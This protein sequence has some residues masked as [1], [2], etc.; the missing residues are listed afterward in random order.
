LSQQGTELIQVQPDRFIHNWRKVGDK[1]AYPRYER[2]KS[3]FEKELRHFS[4]FLS[5]NQM[6]DLN[7]NQCEI[8][9]VNHITSGDGWKDH[10]QIGDVLTLFASRYTDEFRPIPE[11]GRLS[12][13]YVIPNSAGEPIGRLH[14]AVEPVFQSTDDSPMFALTLTTR[15]RPIGDGIT[16][17]LG[18]LDVGRQWIVRT[19]ASITTPKMHT[20]W[21]RKQ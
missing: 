8:T 6:G 17:V 20:V 5:R 15:G 4:D 14:V 18:F 10:S 9:Y 2:V 3:T 13:R 1:D 11:D 12:L 16:G 7:P 21:R 19:F